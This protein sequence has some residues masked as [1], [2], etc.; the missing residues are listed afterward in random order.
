MNPTPER[1]HGVLA[2]LAAQADGHQ[3]ADRVAAIHRRARRTA[4]LR[5]VSVATLVV[6]VLV[7]V[8]VGR[9]HLPL[10]GA[11]RPPP[12]GHGAAPFLHVELTRD[13]QIAAALPPP[14]EGGTN[15][16]IRVRVRALV[17]QTFDEQGKPVGTAPGTATENLL[18]IGMNWGD[19]GGGYSGAEIGSHCLP[20][21]PLVKVDTDF[22]MTHAYRRPGTY[23][24]TLRTGACELGMTFKT[25][26]LTVS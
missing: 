14:E 20:D 12:A 26:T 6:A 10:L 15:V 13:D 8:G 21:A 25:L 16:V 7:T 24:V 22:E 5:A 2:D 23:T 18:G 9:G 1:L 3:P 17:P 19:Y 4:Y 11:D